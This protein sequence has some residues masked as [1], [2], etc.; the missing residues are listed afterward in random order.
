MA[1]QIRWFSFSFVINLK[2]AQIG[3]VT[4]GFLARSILS[5]SLSERIRGSEVTDSLDFDAEFP[6]SQSGYTTCLTERLF[7][8]IRKNEIWHYVLSDVRLATLM[9]KCV[10]HCQICVI[11]IKFVCAYQVDM[12]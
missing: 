12:P 5:V 8:F 1:L 6:V 7:C 10:F 9:I 11:A 3:G 4:L 2:W